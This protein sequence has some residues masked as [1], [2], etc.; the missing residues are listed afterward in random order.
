MDFYQKKSP[1]I[2][3]NAVESELE[4]QKNINISWKKRENYWWIKISV[5]M[6]YNNGVS[7]NNK[8][9]TIHQINRLNPEQ[10]NE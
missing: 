7:E 8:S 1:Q 2:I 10:Q 4:I 3:L 6:W 5:I 9:V